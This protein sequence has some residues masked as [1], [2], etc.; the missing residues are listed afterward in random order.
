[1]ASTAAGGL[2]GLVVNGLAATNNLEP[3]LLLYAI[4]VV[5][6]VYP[7]SFVGAELYRLRQA[8]D[9]L[10]DVLGSEQ[11]YEALLVQAREERE[12]LSAQLEAGRAQAAHQQLAL[13][14]LGI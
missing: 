8:L 9:V 5:V 12:S 13:G 7:A 11:N 1:W 4:L 10:K 3:K 14:V 6:F 2:L